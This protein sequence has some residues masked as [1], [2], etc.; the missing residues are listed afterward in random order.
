[1]RNVARIFF[2]ACAMVASCLAASSALAGP[3]PTDPAALA[4]WQGT[5]SFSFTNPVTLRV[6][7]TDVE[8]AVYAPGQFSSSAALGL[9]VLPLGAVNHYVYA[10]QVYNNLNGLGDVDVTQFS[11]GFQDLIDG[12]DDLEM[13]A[14]ASF[15]PGFGTNPGPPSL[16]PPAL[17]TSVVWTWNPPLDDATMQFSTILYYTS[18]FAPELD[19]ATVNGT[20]AATTRPM[21]SPLPEPSSVVLALFGFAALIF[22]YRRRRGNF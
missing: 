5:T 15:L 11:V 10:Y 7:E 3:L 20:V 17:P 4:A 13:P 19:T 9:P 22:G 2:G 8:F 21:P 1:M 16:G 12:S 6:L 14:N 18:P